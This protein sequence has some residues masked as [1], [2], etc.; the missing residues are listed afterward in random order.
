MGKNTLG[1]MLSFISKAAGTSIIYTNHSVRAT[2]ITAMYQ[3]GIDRSQICRITKYKREESLKH[4][5]SEPSSEQKRTCS[6]VLQQHLGFADNDVSYLEN[7]IPLAETDS[8]SCLLPYDNPV[9]QTVSKDVPV[10]QT[11][12]LTEN[13]IPGLP[14]VTANGINFTFTGGN[15]VFN[16]N[17]Q[18]NNK[19][20]SLTLSQGSN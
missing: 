5:I 17:N 4:Y 18:T 11:V 3:A 20:T 1:T 15:F 8:P 9:D 12:S 13:S 16:I 2:A 6:S 19:E 10:N 14:G 7:A